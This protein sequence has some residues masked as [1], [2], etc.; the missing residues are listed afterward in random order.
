MPSRLSPALLCVLIA[1]G[2]CVSAEKR[3]DQGIRLEQSGRPAEAARRYADAL[4]RDPSLTDARARLQESG[5]RAVEELLGQAQ[6]VP[7]Q[8]GADAFVEVDD[9]LRVSGAVGVTLR[10]PED[11]DRLRRDAFDRAI[12]S[13]IRMAGDAAARGDFDAAASR[14]A[15]AAGRWEASETQRTTIARAR[16]DLLVDW[17]DA[18]LQRGE[19][20]AAHQ[21]AQQAIDLL[22]PGSPNA[23]RAMDVQAEALR[24]GTIRLAVLPAAVTSDHRGHL[25]EGLLAELNDAF[26]DERWRREPLFI[27]IADPREVAREARRRT[28]GR[29][30]PTRSEARA[31]AAAMG[32]DVA[33]LLVID[34]VET[35]ETDVQQQRVPART[36][37]GV[38]TAYTVRSARQEV[39]VRLAYNLLDVEDVQQPERNTVWADAS[40]RVRRATFAGN[41][42]DLVLPN[43][44]DRALFAAST[45][46]GLGNEQVRS[47]AS[48]LAER[49]ERDLLATLERRIR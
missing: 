31:I 12:D 6:A 2:A 47:L 41:P 22:G 40:V 19:Y 48:E 11:Y 14:L 27:A 18:S 25:P 7:P 16:F 30:T 9:L 34:S 46:P 17:A 44:G 5:D 10:V 43:Q 35:R 1:A 45:T 8:E 23:P 15:R 13:A 32:A 24:R 20:R 38:D 49:L 36:R 28:Y 3:V 33:A 29:Q 26:L 21:R 42:A 4:R 39:R 37:G